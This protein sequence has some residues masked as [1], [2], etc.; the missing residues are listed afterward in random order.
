MWYN[1]PFNAEII[2][3]IQTFANPLL[4]EFFVLAT[5]MGEESFFMFAAVFVFWCLDKDFG[6]RLG[7]AYLSN[8]VINSGIKETL[9]IPRPIGEAGIRS[10]RVETAGG[11]SFPSGHSQC[12]SS[13]WTSVMI[14]VKKG[15]MYALGI[16]LILLVGVSRLYLGVH[17][18]IDVFVGIAIGTAWVFISNFMFNFAEKTGKK[19]IFL[20][21]IIPMLALLFVL[22]N[23]ELYK[24]SGTVLAFYLGYLIEPKYIKFEVKAGLIAQALK[25]IIGISVMMG[26]RILVKPLLPEAILSDF[27]R[28]FL[29]GIWVTIGAPF[30]FVKLFGG[31]YRGTGRHLTAGK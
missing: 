1:A 5:M 11:Y 16:V 4:D 29:M 25:L 27:F 14:R 21:F 18:P 9:Q 7:F 10:M 2:K 3:F 17:R 20:I 8:G 22:P 15:W 30:I 6:Y 13:F 26:I 19:L 23:A 24:S 12:A 31:A 28:Y